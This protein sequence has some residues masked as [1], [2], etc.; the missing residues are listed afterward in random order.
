MRVV[1]TEYADRALQALVAGSSNSI[2]CRSINISSHSCKI[3][4]WKSFF[5]P[6]IYIDLVMDVMIGL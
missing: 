6:E 1:V 3:L 2:G 5:K 4:V